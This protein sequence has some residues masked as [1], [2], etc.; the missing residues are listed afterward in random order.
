MWCRSADPI[1]RPRAAVRRRS[2]PDD[3]TRRDHA[4]YNHWA[5][6][7]SVQ[8]REKNMLEDVRH[9]E[10]RYAVAARAAKDGLWEW[11]R[12]TGV[13]YLSDRCRELIGSPPT[14]PVDGARSLPLW[15]HPDDWSGSRSR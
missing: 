13:L 15:T 12:A 14:K 8:F 3:S 2:P 6:L 5:A 4:A 7:L 10:E 11:S 9:S 1:G